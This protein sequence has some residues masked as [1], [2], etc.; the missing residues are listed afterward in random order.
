MSK[1]KP[2]WYWVRDDVEG[3][4][5]AHW[6]A[7]W[8]S[9]FNIGAVSDSDFSEIGPRIL[10]PDESQLDVDALAQHIRRVDGNNSMGTGAL[11]ESICEWLAA[12]KSEDV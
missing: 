11:A 6:A 4:H 10:S 3:W 9:P 5:P 8:T 7:F 12:P 1:R 2:G